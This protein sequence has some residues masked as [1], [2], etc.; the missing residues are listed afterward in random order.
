[1]AK[2]SI[3][4]RQRKREK[5]VAKYATKRTQLKSVIGDVNAPL[6]QR[7]LAWKKLQSL[8]RDSS[9]IRKRNRC[10]LTGRPRRVYRQFGLSG[11]MLR[12]LAMRGELPGI[13]KSSW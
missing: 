7:W 11:G 2:K 6:E 13:Q 9:A 10:I 5:L 12:I 8:P 3:L 4:M 1:M